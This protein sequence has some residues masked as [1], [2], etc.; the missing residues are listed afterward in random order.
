MS[1][2]LSEF[3]KDGIR[4]HIAAWWQTMAERCVALYLPTLFYTRRHLGY[5]KGSEHLRAARLNEE[6]YRESYKQ[7]VKQM[8]PRLS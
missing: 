3:P 7:W 6:E 2:I 5:L 4:D 8:S 1:D